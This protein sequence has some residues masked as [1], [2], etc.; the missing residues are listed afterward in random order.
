MSDAQLAQVMDAIGSAVPSKKDITK[1]KA[2]PEPE[3]P[4][5]ADSLTPLQQYVLKATFGGRVKPK[6]PKY[7]DFEKEVIK[8]WTQRAIPDGLSNFI[9]EQDPT[10]QVPRKKE[11]RAR[12]FWDTLRK[13]R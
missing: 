7:G 9:T 12:L 6:G 4:E 13:M 3:A 8:L 5:D 2:E 11:D 1:D 10:L